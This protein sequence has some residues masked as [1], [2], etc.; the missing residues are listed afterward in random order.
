MKKILILSND[1]GYT[2]SL[3]KELILEF[4]NKGFKVIVVCPKGRAVSK[5]LIIGATHLNWK[6][7]SHSINPILEFYSYISLSKIIKAQKPSHI[8]S[9]TIKPNIYSGLLKGRYNF[10]HIPNITGLGKIFSKNNIFM[11]FII[12][13]YK[14]SFK[15]SKVIFLQNSSDYSF[16]K[17]L[18]IFPKKLV[19]IPG[20]G[21]NVDEFTFHKYPSEKKGINFLYLGRIMKK[22]G[23]DLYLDAAK[24]IKSKH[25]NINF[26]VCGSPDLGYERKLKSAIS[27][28]IIIYKGNLMDV[29]DEIIHSHALIQPSFYPEGISNVILEAS[30]MGR[31]VITSDNVGCGEAI[32]DNITGFIFQ[33]QNVEDLIKKIELFINLSQ[34]QKTELSFNARE[35]VKNVYNRNNVVNAYL[36]NI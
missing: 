19:L 13:L 4:I 26:I 34:S 7:N 31:P 22:K 25:K 1:A 20:S 33:K 9:F 6:L 8:L 3:R 29:K 2:Y 5:L 18:N 16:F 35:H 32:I 28:E 36:S 11:Q 27:E 10:I 23:I 12:F 21:V 17:Q 15:Q 30:S 24:R 14:L